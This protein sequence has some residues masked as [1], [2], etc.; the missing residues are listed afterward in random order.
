MDEVARQNQ[1]QQK[2]ESQNCI[3][4][5]ESG[6]NNEAPTVHSGITIPKKIYPKGFI[7]PIEEGA[8]IEGE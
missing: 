6:S 7:G 5:I 8:V 2:R 4:P 1:A 3:I